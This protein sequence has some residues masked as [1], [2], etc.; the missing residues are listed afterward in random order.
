MAFGAKEQ[1]NLFYIFIV[2]Y[3]SSLI[4][5]SMLVFGAEPQG[6]NAVRTNFSSTQIGFSKFAGVMN[7]IVFFVF[8]SLAHASIKTTGLFM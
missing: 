6:A 7:W 5:Q 3:F 8:I 2:I 4:V 1:I